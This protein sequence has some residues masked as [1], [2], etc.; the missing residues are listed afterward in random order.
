MPSL[1]HRTQNE[2]DVLKR[3]AESL[4]PRGSGLVAFVR[5][6]RDNLGEEPGNRDLVFLYPP[7]VGAAPRVGVLDLGIFHETVLFEVKPE[8]CARFQ[9]SVTLDVAWRDV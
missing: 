5:L 1:G 4:P 6:R 9:S 7:A 2:L 3:P 8:Y